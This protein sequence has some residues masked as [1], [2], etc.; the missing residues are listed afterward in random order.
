V[1][2]NLGD[3]SA[4]PGSPAEAARQA[5]S[6]GKDVQR[7]AEDFGREAQRQAGSLGDKVRLVPD[8]SVPSCMPSR[9]NCDPLVLATSCTWVFG[10]WSLSFFL[11]GV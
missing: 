3:L 10:L 5:K 4:L 6:A 7:Q 8:P 9:L 1:K 2:R 11:S